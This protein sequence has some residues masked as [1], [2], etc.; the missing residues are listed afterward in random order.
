MAVY[1]V[2]TS[3]W[4]SAAFWSGI[5]ETA[6]GHTLDLNAL[7]ASYTVTL[8]KASGVLTIS[9]GGSSFTIGESGHSGP[10]DAT[11]GGATDWSLFTSLDLEHSV[12]SVTG[13]GQA[14]TIDVGDADNVIDAGAGN[15][16]I[17]TGS[18][19]NTV[20]SGDGEDLITSQG[21]DDYLSGDG[22]SD[23]IYANDGAD[24][25]DGGLGAD[26]LFGGAG[27]DTL[28]GGWSDAGA[29]TIFGGTGDDLVLAG[30]G[31]DDLYGDEGDDWLDGGAGA[32]SIVGGIGYDRMVGADGDDT[33][34]G[35]DEGDT[36]TG[37]AGSDSLSGGGGE[38][39]IWGYAGDTVD[40]GEAGSDNDFLYVGDVSHV[41][42]TTPE[43]GTVHFLSTGDTLSFTNIENVVFLASDGIVTGTSG[44]DDIGQFYFDAGGDWVDNN[45]ASGA[46]GMTG[47]QDS[48]NAGA[49]ND[50]VWAMEGA[51]S[52]DGGT[53]NDMLDGGSG[54][55]TLLGGEGADTLY[56]DG[57]NDSL[58]GGT[59]ADSLLG[60]WGEDT[61][62]GGGG[63]DTI[64]GGTEADV[65][66][67]GDGSD[68]FSFSYGFGNDL[69]QGG[70]G[71]VDNDTLD[72]SSMSQGLA[73]WITTNETG[74]VTNGDNG[75]LINFSEIES[76]ALTSGNDTVWGA[77]ADDNMI[78]DG[79]AGN[80][81]INA[82]SGDD[83]L[84]TG[85][86]NDSISGGAG[87]D[88]LVG[89]S[90]GGS[91]YSLLEGGGGADTI[92]GTLG[93]WDVAA[94]WSSGS[95]INID[96]T[97]GSPESGGEA[98]GDVLIG[99]EQIDASAFDDTIKADDSIR[100]VKGN[101]GNDWI[102]TGDT[103]AR[104]FGGDGADTV[105][106]GDGD[107]YLDA[108][109]AVAGNDFI[110][111]GDGHDTLLADAGDDTLYDQGGDDVV[112][113]G[114]G[115]DVISLGTGD[116]TVYGQ[117]GSDFFSLWAGTGND[118][119]V[120]GEGGTDEDLVQVYTA[121]T[122]IEVTYAGTET[123]TMSFGADTVGFSEIEQ[124][125]L[126]D[127]DDT[128]D[129]SASTVGVYVK[130][131]EGADSMLGGSGSDTLVG[132]EG[133]DTLAGGGGDDSLSGG[134]G[135][136]T[137]VL[138]DGFGSDT[139]TGGETITLVS[140]NDALD[141]QNLTA[142]V[143][144]DLSQNGAADTE[145]GVIIQGADTLS[146]TEIEETSGTDHADTVTGSSGGDHLH[147]NGGADSVDAGDGADTIHGDAGADT[148]HGGDGED[149]LL[150]DADADSLT[151]GAGA[152]TLLGGT[153]DDTL[154]GGAGA[155][156][157]EGGAGEDFF[158]IGVGDTAQGDDGDDTFTTTAASMATGNATITGGEG[159][160]TGGD[161]LNITGPATIDMLGTESGTVTWLDGSVLT[162]SEIEQINYTP[163]F[164]PGTRIKMDKGQKRAEHVRVGD[165][166]QTRDSGVKPVRW[167][168]S[169]IL[170]KDE[171]LAER[172]LQP[173][174]IKQGALG[175]GVPKRDM[176]VSPQHRIALGNA[177][178]QLWTGEDDVLVA[179]QDLL[180]LPGVRRA[181]PQQGVRYIH[182]MFD[183]HELVKSDG[184]WTESF[185]PGDLF[186]AGLDGA[187]RREL[188]S[189]F[190][191][192][193]QP[194]CRNL[195]FAAA[196]PA[197][198]SYQAQVVLSHLCA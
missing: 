165:L 197:L 41:D 178:V 50:N 9:D 49:G 81:D 45:D 97:D 74:T 33:I 5:H 187:Q 172:N 63:D 62:F 11:L 152:D 177:Q 60:Q 180:H 191:D 105:L 125:N 123:G 67:G 61:V 83:T 13:D 84:Y 183:R 94:Y 6:S 127:S 134:A 160:E 38:D 22:G 25:V 89:N 3:N 156:S 36:L 17:T 21:G 135:S 106:G 30:D 59:G 102:E 78:V 68:V 88:S 158:S 119:I 32:D 77:G 174:R 190:P 64:I 130:A 116:D 98:A 132:E 14:E 131:G 114:S 95:G 73:V 100:E 138:S 103:G 104:V 129:A 19:N 139:V 71:G 20:H 107:D 42:Y 137:F 118:V 58:D 185:Q 12:N 48:I 110:Q 142:G 189:L 65:L 91:T 39:H 196:R 2:T 79:G 47:Q 24:I 193:A 175:A 54:A 27:A 128:L 75:D 15:D 182:L 117:D 170:T 194:D 171:L 112:Y 85:D 154:E 86:G 43:S 124:F 16:T 1:T 113:A 141:L 29:D 55:D 99:I 52:V 150:G 18:G 23:T 115:D 126:T 51:D 153:G 140:D 96:L 31:L 122:G 181:V 80:D 57:D 111:A 164:T 53:G 35:G 144:I 56:G 87:D 176:M 162:F 92:D 28:A 70:E 101:A 145:S 159:G 198:K 168:G 179:A 192:L 133:D 8:D 161:T 166:V 188:L 40:G 46:F 120:G 184:C 169:K 149:S 173:I 69:I 148:I 146:F 72:F 121:T 26:S 4:N 157:L 76:F 82:G 10:A 90:A 108:E 167:I 109:D 147:V 34:F 195:R 151:G 93:N 66:Y 7:T 186:L 136:D 155:D 143:N 44:N 37:G 163:C